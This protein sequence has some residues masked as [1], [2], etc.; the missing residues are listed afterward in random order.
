MRLVFTRPV[1]NRIVEIR[2]YLAEN[3]SF[4]QA[5]LTIS[6]LLDKA[7]SLLEH[8][9]RGIPEPAL[10]DMGKGHRSLITGRYKIV[11]YVSGDEIRIT[12]LLDTKQHSSGMRW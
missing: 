3:T 4:E 6:K 2:N 9:M 1:R 11:Y 7:D 8:P 10:A 12:D 5:D